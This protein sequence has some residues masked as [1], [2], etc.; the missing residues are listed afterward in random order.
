MHPK[1]GAA[2]SPRS[3]QIAWRLTD[4]LVRRAQEVFLPSWEATHGDDGYV[5]FELDPLIEDPA[6][7]ISTEEGMRRYVEWYRE[8]AD[9]PPSSV[10]DE[11]ARENS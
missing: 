4:M 5:S 8:A 7:G 6:A 10:S 11:T 1:T 2:S 3:A 9:V